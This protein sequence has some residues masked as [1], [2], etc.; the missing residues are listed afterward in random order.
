VQKNT[1][2]V[3]DDRFLDHNPGPGHPE[4]PDRLRTIVSHLRNEDL[5]ETFTHIPVPPPDESLLYC[6]HTP[7]YVQSVKEAC[8]NGVTIL[9]EG[10]TQVGENSFDIAS[11]AVSGVLAG[12]RAVTEGVVSNAF[13]AVRPP[14]HHAERTRAMGFCL[15]NNAAIA[16]RYALS[17]CHCQR[18]AILDWDVHHGNGT[19]HAFY[20]D[21]A[22]FFVS[23]HQY[24]FYPGTGSREE[25]GS[26]KGLGSTLNM[27]MA[28]GSGEEEYVAAFTNEILP[29]FERFKP[30]LVL[31]SAGFDAHRD[32][33]LA[34]IMLTESSFGRMTTMIRT[35]AKSCCAGK[36]VSILEGGYHLRA[37]PLSVEAHLRALQSV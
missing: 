34:H 25:T 1:G 32:D 20:D 9:D 11:L 27:P 17:A 36:I 10:D 35:F 30:D 22:V 31:L 4:R 16:A 21:P 12:V 14:G 37:L 15:F 13:C 33:P 29:A 6:V 26:R 19:Q 2:I 23:L 5:W 24:P 8:R 18:V 28:A 3:Y 7:E